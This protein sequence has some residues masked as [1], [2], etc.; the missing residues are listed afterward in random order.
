M[1]KRF[2]IKKRIS[3]SML[4]PD[5]KELMDEFIR[6]TVTNCYRHVLKKGKLDD[7][8]GNVYFDVFLIPVDV[9]TKH[10]GIGFA[11]AT[12]EFSKE[13]EILAIKY[14]DY[15]KDKDSSCV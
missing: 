8:E 5:K 9:N 2:F 4:L 14:I 3:S 6:R 7:L 12:F 1:E 15:G 13:G 10:D 11:F